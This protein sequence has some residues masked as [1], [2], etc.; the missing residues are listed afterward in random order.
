MVRG[1]AVDG[2]G[3]VVEGRGAAAGPVST[4]PDSVDYQVRVEEFAS[5][6]PF[7]IGGVEMTVTNLSATTFDN[8][9]DAVTG[10]GTDD[11]GQASGPET[12]PS[13]ETL[14]LAFT[15]AW[16]GSGSSD[17]W[18]GVDEAGGRWDLDE[19]DFYTGEAGHIKF[20]LGDGNG[21][22]L[23]VELDNRYDDDSVH[24]VVINKS[25]NTASDIDVYV[26]DMGSTEPFTVRDDGGFNH[27]DY[28]VSS[29]LAFWARNADGSIERYKQMRA[30]VFEFWDS[31]LSQSE[32]DDFVSRRP[33]V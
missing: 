20:S 33:E 29:D 7:N 15:T 10:D 4:I 26:D 17:N 22:S 28:S 18:L 16:P 27:A 2:R 31:P 24:A 19:T 9:E 14:G 12:I 30:A 21:N 13:N 1:Y 5:P 6:W 23:T 3:L 32:R 11:Y 8:G 25:G